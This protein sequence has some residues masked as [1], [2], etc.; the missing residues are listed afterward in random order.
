MLGQY[1]GLSYRTGFK[2]CSLFPEI[3]ADTR[4]SLVA[5]ELERRQRAALELQEQREFEDL[6]V[7]SI[8]CIV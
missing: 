4:D 3:P 6:Q 1:T 2:T 8:P 5:Q 7:N